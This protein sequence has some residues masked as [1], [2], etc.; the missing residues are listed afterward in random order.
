[1]LEK[2]AMTTTTKEVP[3]DLAMTMRTSSATMMVIT[4]EAK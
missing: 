1:M 3:L 2:I 4:T